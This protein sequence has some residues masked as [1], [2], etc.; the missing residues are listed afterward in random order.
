MQEILSKIIFVPITDGSTDK[1]GPGHGYIAIV[2]NC[3]FKFHRI[4]RCWFTGT[5]NCSI[6]ITFILVPAIKKRN[7]LV[8]VVDDRK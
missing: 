7:E 6:E 8:N 3:S 1:I 4:L 5:H 2:L